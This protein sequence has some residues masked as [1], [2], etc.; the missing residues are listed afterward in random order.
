LDARPSVLRFGEGFSRLRS[1]LAKAEASLAI[2]AC[3]N[4]RH[5]G[6]H[7]DGVHFLPL[8]ETLP[9][10]KLGEL[11]AAYLPADLTHEHYPNLIDEGATIPTIANRALLVAYTWPEASPPLQE[12]RQVHRCVL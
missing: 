2:I 1:A 10:H 12:G 8:D 9:N 4:A 6:G 3:A 5:F 7:V 11:F